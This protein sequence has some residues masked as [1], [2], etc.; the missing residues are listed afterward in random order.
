M[1]VKDRIFVVIPSYNEE[2]RLP[3]TLVKLQKYHP[4]NQVIVVDDGSKNPIS[5]YISS[6]V[7]I[8][9]HQVN[10][11]KGMALKTGCETAIKLGATAVVLMDADGQH[12]PKEIPAFIKLLKQGYLMVFG[13][14][15][16]GHGMP[17]WRLL[18]NRGLNYTATIL[19]G[20]KLHDIWCGYRAFKV[21]IYPKIVWE[22]TDY[23]SDVQMAVKVGLHHISHIEHFVGTIYHD[24]GS[25]TGTTLQD[26]LKLLIELLIWRLF[27]K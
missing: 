23:S 16:I 22:A 11:G 21:S 6:R 14:R 20:L 4:L 26:G 9:R 10:L 3:N 2:F 25:V 27:L 7:T 8:I 19:F 5:K 15:Y 13:A 17:T 1:K 24:K 12:D 18:G